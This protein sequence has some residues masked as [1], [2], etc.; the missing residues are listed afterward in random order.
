MLHSNR[1]VAAL[2]LVLQEQHDYSALRISLCNRREY[3]EP[4]LQLNGQFK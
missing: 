1:Y 4:A 2:A 3:P